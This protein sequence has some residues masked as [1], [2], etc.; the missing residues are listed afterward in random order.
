MDRPVKTFA[1]G[2]DDADFNELQYAQQVA[3]LF[4]CEHTEYV[5]KP[6]ALQVLPVNYPSL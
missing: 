1:I 5:V 3:D 6:D 2:F 4:G